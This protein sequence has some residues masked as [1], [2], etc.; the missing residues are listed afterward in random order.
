MSEATEEPQSCE[1]EEK[2]EL[3]NLNLIYSATT[4][5]SVWQYCPGLA[6]RVCWGGARAGDGAG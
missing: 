6:L 5:V 2:Y 4:E 3:I 1:G